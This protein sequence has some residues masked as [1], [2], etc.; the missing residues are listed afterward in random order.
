MTNFRIGQ[1]V[2]VLV[3]VEST[4]RTKGQTAVIERIRGRLL[5]RCLHGKFESITTVYDDQHTLW[6]NNCDIKLHNPLPI[7]PIF[8]R[9][10]CD[11]TV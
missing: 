5:I 6:V 11:E 10:V 3:D 2:T 8:L 1:K 7:S 9:E 4:W